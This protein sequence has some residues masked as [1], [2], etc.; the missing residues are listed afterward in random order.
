MVVSV[1]VVVNV[2]VVVGAFVA[3]CVLVAMCSMVLWQ[4]FRVTTRK[5]SKEVKVS[6]QGR[7]RGQDND[8]S[9]AKGFVVWFTLVQGQG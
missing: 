7:H 4:I 6:G 9:Y 8:C 5:R 3:A 1:R 2:V